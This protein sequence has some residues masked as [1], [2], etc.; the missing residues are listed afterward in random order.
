MP[1]PLWLKDVITWFITTFGGEIVI[2][3]KDVLPN[4]WRRVFA[5]RNILILGDKDTGKTSLVLYLQ[6]GR[7]YEIVDGE[8]RLPNSTAGVGAVV[9]KKFS[10][11]HGNWL[12]LKKDLPGDLDFRSTWAQAIKD[13]RPHGIIYMVDGR[14]LD[15]EISGVIAAGLRQH[16]LQHYEKGLRE[17]AAVHVFVNFADEWANSASSAR[18]KERLIMDAFDTAIQGNAA[19]SH[20]R[21]SVSA[22][23]LSPNRKTWQETSRA[24]YRFG[25]DLME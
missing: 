18:A 17:L 10:L 13:I 19:L 4:Q 20:L 16:I 15:D 1:I 23:Q 14:L 12:K 3:A 9:D 2:L 5:S 22:T 21:F 24:L 25:A 7:P 11:Q 8:I 6:H